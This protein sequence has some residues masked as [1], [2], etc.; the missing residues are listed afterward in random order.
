MKSFYISFALTITIL[1]FCSCHQE[2]T[3]QSAYL[4]F[5]GIDLHSSDNGLDYFCTISPNEAEFKIYCSKLLTRVG[6]NG[7]IFVA[8]NGKPELEGYWGS[9]TVSEKDKLYLYQIHINTNNSGKNRNFQFKFG[10][11]DTFCFINIQQ[12]FIEKNKR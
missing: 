9:I 12:L 8:N 7:V 5:E 4:K 3:I 1:L 11:G 6:T 2:S 10:T